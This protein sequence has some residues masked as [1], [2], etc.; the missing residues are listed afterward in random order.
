MSIIGDQREL[1]DFYPLLRGGDDAPV[2]KMER[3]LRNGAARGGQ[4]FPATGI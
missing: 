3:Y 2:K 1:V 4:T